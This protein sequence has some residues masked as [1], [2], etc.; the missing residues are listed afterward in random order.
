MAEKKK[1]RYLVWVIMILVGIGLLGFGT[2][3]LSGNVR[4][5][6][7][8]GDKDISVASYQNVLSQQI[9]AIEAQIGT[10]IGFQ[11]AESFGVVA[12]AQ[13]QLITNRTLDNEATN[14][15]ISVGDERVRTEVLRVPA[16]QGLNGQF[17]RESYSNALQRNGLTESDFEASIREEMARTLLQGGVVGGIPAPT[18]YAD[19]LVQFV[20]ERRD[21]VWSVVSA[22]NLLDAIP[23]PSQSDLTAFY[24]QNP[25]RFTLP[26]AREITYAWLT[27]DMIQD[28]LDIDETSMR[29]VYD[30]RIADFVRPERRLV[31]RLVFTDVETAT[32]A[33]SRVTAS[34]VDFDALVTERGLDLADVDL[35]DVAIEDLGD[36]GE[37][38]FAAVPGDV[39]GPL[40][41]SLGPALFRMNAVLAAEEIT[42][43]A[44]T[45]QLREELSEI[46][47]RAVIADS[48]EII[49]D[50]IAGGAT[51]EDLAAETDMKIGQISWTRDSQSDIAAYEAFRTAAAEVADGDFPDLLN[52]AD[53]GV[54]ALRRDGVTPP[55]VQ[56]IADVSDGVTSGWQAEAT[57]QA[58]IA[59]AEDIATEVA[60]L[61]NFETLGLTAT[62]ESGLTR[63]SFV[64]GT[65]PGF[66][67][68]V[69]EMAIGEKRV[70]DNG[71]SA[72]IVRLDAIAAPDT[73]DPQ[74]RAERDAVGDAAAAGIAQDVFEAFA[75]SV[76]SRTDISLDQH[77][78]SAVHSQ[79][80]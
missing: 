19:A 61:T 26:E 56:P 17:D 41:T 78:I 44:A 49:N 69:F 60:P 45:P 52:L 67:V 30:E 71:N 34:E 29:E 21:F 37:A 20:G 55:T 31:E 54:F 53:G 72:I 38:V 58:V 25:D 7:K 10:R 8:V 50:L 2:G 15:G 32:A 74:S 75:A 5:I 47:A 43:E 73:Q 13:A 35:G 24:E 36:A 63:R 59:R 14:L 80:Q 12:A 18:A 68:E 64:E 46:R 39:V 51:L 27:P 3:G 11:Q 6:G 33:L 48:S 23:A 1:S 77:I 40:N 79:L 9:R 57:Q 16:F 65:P 22:D 28:S 42:F 66:M 62:T 70:I 4:S 76:Q